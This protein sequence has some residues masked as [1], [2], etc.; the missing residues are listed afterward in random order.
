MAG[1]SWSTAPTTAASPHL[2]PM[3]FDG[4]AAG[5]DLLQDRGRSDRHD[6]ARHVQQLRLGPHA[7]GHLPDLRRELQRLFR[8]HRREPCGPD[9]VHRRRLQALRHRRKW[10]GLRLPQVGRRWDD[11][12]TPTSRTARA[13]S[14]RSIPA[15]P[16]STPVKHTALGRFKHENA[17]YAIARRPRFVVYMGDDERGEYMYKWVSRDLC[18]RWR[19]LDACWSEGTLLRQP[20][21]TTT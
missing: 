10:L 20:C 17:A 14:S 3:S 7:L 19:H 13:T 21:S 4:P 8:L 16:E 5:H 12:R 1:R 6:V 18:G 11:T 9:E 2:T 15:N